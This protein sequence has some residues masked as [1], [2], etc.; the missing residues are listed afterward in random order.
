MRS[1]A[2][3]CGLLL[4][5]PQG[6]CCMFAFACHEG[7]ATTLTETAAG[8]QDSPGRTGECCPCCPHKSAPGAPTGEP[9]PTEKPSAPAK[10]ICSCSD[11]PATLPSTSSVEQ[12][13]DGLVLFLPPLPAI[14]GVG[15]SVAV[16]GTELPPPT[17]T[18]HVLNC[19]WLC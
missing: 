4:A 13:N 18:L 10:S 7:K 8:T 1:L 12:V 14:Q 11:R 19:V 17:P 15:H 5:L 9:T 6:W 3:A 16:V 2:L